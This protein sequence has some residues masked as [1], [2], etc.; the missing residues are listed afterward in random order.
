MLSQG[1]MTSSFLDQIPLI[2]NLYRRQRR[3][4]VSLINT[5]LVDPLQ[6]PKY[7][8]GFPAVAAKIGI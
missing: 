5:L 2:V 8:I 4:W 7:S 1:L 6:R 3:S